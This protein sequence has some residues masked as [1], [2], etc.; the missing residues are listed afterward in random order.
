MSCEGKRDEVTHG[1]RV[2]SVPGM[3][4]HILQGLVVV[5]INVVV[6]GLALLSFFLFIFRGDPILAAI[7]AVIALP[8]ILLQPWFI[9][10]FFL[11][12]G[13]LLAPIL[14]T[15][16]SIPL[17]IALDRKTKLDRAK[18]YLTRL[19]TR[20]TLLLVVGFIVFMLVVSFARYND[21]PPM[22]RGVPHP[23]EYSFK[24]MKVSFG[25]PR[26]YRLGSFIDSEWLWQAR[27]SDKDLHTVS[28]RLDMHP[29]TLNQIG[30][31]F[32]RMPPY[33]WRPVISDR[34]QV[35][36]T[37]NFPMQ[38]RGSDGL[39]LLATWNPEDQILHMWIKDNF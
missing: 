24:N 38:S 3:K 6:G 39:H 5:G 32:L 7:P 14:T 2:W 34:I 19:K 30:D 9:V 29:I 23:L 21:F 12:S 22:H 10:F 20:K 8:A 11:P 25:D 37:T 31:E 13:P 33:W 18:L 17:Y 1:Q 4:R 27:V 36:A 35:F 15:A 16:V 26:Y 28:D